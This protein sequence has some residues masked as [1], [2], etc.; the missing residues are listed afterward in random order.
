[1]NL[2]LLF[3]P[4][5]KLLHFRLEVNATASEEIFSRILT[6]IEQTMANL[7]ASI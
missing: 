1:M 2:Q 6:L 3:P 5:E 4:A 7:F